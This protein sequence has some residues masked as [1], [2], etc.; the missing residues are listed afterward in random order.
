MVI[1]QSTSFSIPDFPSICKGETTAG[2][3]FSPAISSPV[4][5]SIQWQTPPS[6]VVNPT[7][8]TNFQGSTANVGVSSNAA[9]GNYGISSISVTNIQTGCVSTQS[10]NPTTSYLEI[11]P[12]PVI[13]ALASSTVCEGEI[14]SATSIQLATAISGS[15]SGS[16][17]V[18]QTG[19]GLSP[20]SGLINTLP[21]SIGSFTSAN[22]G[23]SNLTANIQ[24]T[25]VVNGCS[26]VS[27]VVVKQIV[28]KPKPFISLTPASSF[29]ICDTSSTINDIPGA[30]TITTD[31]PGTLYSWTNSNTTTGVPSGNANQTIAS[32][33]TNLLSAA[34]W[35]PLNTT[36]AVNTS[37]LTITSTYNGCAGNTITDYPIN[38]NPTPVPQNLTLNP[39]CSGTSLGP[40]AFST[41]LAGSMTYQWS[42]AWTS[43]AP[44][45]YPT[46]PSTGSIPST[47]YTNTTNTNL[48][49]LVS[50]SATSVSSTCKSRTRNVGSIN[51]RPQL[52]IVVTYDG[53][54]NPP[55][56]SIC[57]GNTVP[58][59]T[60]SFS[61]P[62]DNSISE[63][64]VFNWTKDLTTISS[65]VLPAPGPTTGGSLPTFVAAL[66]GDPSLAEQSTFDVNA[67]FTIDGTSTVCSSPVSQQQFIIQVNPGP[68]LTVAD[69]TLNAQLCDGA[70]FNQLNLGTLIEPSNSS[71]TWICD[72]ASIDG[73]GGIGIDSVYS[74]TIPSFTGNNPVPNTGT[75]SGVF[76]VVLSST[77]T[78]CKSTFDFIVDINPKP[79]LL[80][81]STDIK[82]CNENDTLT[83]V[84]NIAGGIQYN[85]T[86]TG[87]WG[88]Q[89]VNG[90]LLYLDPNIGSSSTVSGTTTITPTVI[91]TG[92][93]GAPTTLNVVV[94][95]VPV[96]PQ[97]ITEETTFC[98]NTSFQPFISQTGILASDSTGY[99]WNLNP[100]SVGN[101]LPDNHFSNILIDFNNTASQTATLTLKTTNKA[102]N[103]YSDTSIVL[104]FSGDALDLT[105]D[106]VEASVGGVIENLIFFKDPALQIDTYQWG[107]DDF[108]T[109]LSYEIAS[110]TNQILTMQQVGN[111][112]GGLNSMVNELFTNGANQINRYNFWVRISNGQC[113][114]KVY[115]LTDGKTFPDF[116]LSIQNSTSTFS[117]AGDIGIIV[118]PNPT[119]GLINISSLKSKNEKISLTVFSS[120]GQ[121]IQQKTEWISAQKSN[122]LDL[123]N[124]E[125]G[126]YFIRLSD[127]QGNNQ[128]VKLIKAN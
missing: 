70:P 123:T 80:Q 83:L 111:A 81:P 7:V 10:Y 57:N 3:I 122:I 49:G 58:T 86:K 55:V 1:S 37:L 89:I 69:S 112:N 34:S 77:G 92:C 128:V 67:T 95:S 45:S 96:N 4:N 2:F 68:R 43:G 97:I 35:N 54:I 105:G 93:S 125:S 20:A 24:A 33:S 19:I 17:S 91:S 41:N 103:C 88:T 104:T 6:G 99:E 8:I 76:T 71:V 98:A 47:T 53:E 61:S 12:I 13:Q 21:F 121:L 106:I 120:T 101:I 90:N 42:V 113:H 102:T 118:F 75:I 40:V 39:I 32:I 109:M 87:N 65:P 94:N 124:I 5:I 15:V 60:I 28:V 9:A 11:K 73:A 50:V 56:I 29:S 107:Y 46:G 51:V 117:T 16:W 66:V 116:P 25:V 14:V 110:A 84:S 18:D 74:N 79:V 44:I 85:A 52:D 108:T 114:T 115:Y 48:T 26:S 100:S 59:G 27:N 63:N 78:A 30:I 62:I 23:T 126:L 22:S 64:I 36:N 31:I 119:N 127:D 38:V 72:N 82:L